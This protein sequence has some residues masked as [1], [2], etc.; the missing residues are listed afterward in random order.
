MHL[1]L[2]PKGSAE[3]AED[4]ATVAIHEQL[5]KLD[6]DYTDLEAMLGLRPLKV[7]VLPNG[8]FRAYIMK[9][10]AAGADLAHLK[11]PHVNPSDAAIDAL[12]T[13]VP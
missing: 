5:K 2:E 3:I 4:Q 11:P 7:T 9:Q 13:P 1:Y 6:K 12:L 8:A 10:R